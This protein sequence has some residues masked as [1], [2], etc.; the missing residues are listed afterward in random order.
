MRGHDRIQTEIHR[1]AIE[2]IVNEM[3]LTLVRTSGSPIVTDAKDFST[4]LLDE[5]GEQLG[6]GCY[7]LLH[8]ATSWMN[9][10]AV[11]EE[12]RRNGRKPRR[13]DGWIVNDPYTAGAQHQGD[14]GIV[15]PTFYG[16][17]HVGWA[18]SNLH[19]LDI[20]GMGVSGV[21]LAAR[22]VYDEA[23]RFGVIQVIRDGQLDEEWKR[24]IVQNVR[25]PS[26]VL[27]DI[28]SMIAANNV[29]ETKLAGVI[30][31]FGVDAHW[32]HNERN[33]QLTEELLRRRI[34]ALPDGRYEAAEYIEL[35][36]GGSDDLIEVRCALEVEGS[37]LSFSF[38]GD[39]QVQAPINGT[40]GTACG[41]VMAHIVT[42]LGYGDL[43]FNAGMWAPLT[44]DIG[45]PG[46]V[47]NAVPPAPVSLGHAE[48]G[49][50][51]G[52][53]ARNA[54]TQAVSLSADP[55][56]RGRAS[57]A[58]SEAAAVAFVFGIGD[59]GAP[60][61][62]AYM[63]TLQGT[64]G[65]AQT[66]ADGQDMYGWVSTAGGGL[67]DLELHE[68]TDPVLFLWR[69]ITKNSGGPGQHRGGQGID[70]AYLLRGGSTLAGFANLA[71]A[72]FPPPGSG[73]GFPP[74]VSLHYPVRGVAYSP[75][76][77][78]ATRPPLDEQTLGGTRE[79][80]S[81]KVANFVF[82]PG[83]A[84]HVVCGGGGGLGDPLLRAPELVAEDLRNGYITAEHA[85][86]AYGVIVDR[87]GNV[88]FSAT[89]AGRVQRRRE[90]IGGDP[91]REAAVPETPGLSVAFSRDRGA[92]HW[93][94]AHCSTE[95][96]PLDHDWRD[97]V[98]KRELPISEFFASLGMQVRARERGPKVTITCLYCPSCASCL[99]T[100]V[101]TDRTKPASPK[102]TVRDAVAG[103]LATSAGHG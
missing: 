55:V 5:R 48:S 21:A 23:L 35:D 65:G 20:G 11:I 37:D 15:M 50:R 8:S 70:Q 59:N 63:D 34:E 56:L 89:E 91:V 62:L 67:P 46:T 72:E 40:R 51:C 87:S 18:F 53:A 97:A 66:V 30:K 28:R 100:D 43:P 99:A 25:T 17:E 19:V 103:T 82:N 2:N 74:S 32:E 52:K 85:Q 14:V 16:D 84:L 73:G 42:M 10:E 78:N 81:K 47:V 1:K 3:A 9:T 68:A 80:V 94:C 71:C 31:R 33:K 4:C 60:A 75:D 49:C 27:N 79:T 102:L 86:A 98:V 41:A 22:S 76:M 7:V 12:L 64:G 77:V 101:A 6:L 96:A 90:R 24:Y 39:P 57:G 58:A 95:I 88:D 83:D 69:R 54:L 44:I 45:A 93:L 92:H 13:G 61:L 26:P 36:G 38:S 29:A